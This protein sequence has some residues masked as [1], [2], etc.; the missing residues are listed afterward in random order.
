MINMVSPPKQLSRM[1]HLRFAAMVCFV[2]SI[3]AANA[4]AQVTVW[5]GPANGDF[6]SAMNWTA[7]APDAADSAIFN[8]NFSGGVTFSGSID[9]LD[10]FLRNTAGT[11]TFDVDPLNSGNLFRMS[12]FTI[13]GA[14]AGEA[15]QMVVTSG[16]L[17]TGIVLI[18]NADGANNNR[19]EVTGAGTYWKATGGTGGTAAIACRQ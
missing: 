14:A 5:N 10:L 17:E 8:N 18:G 7:G 3:I 16:D 9:T 15:N 4:M 12:R 6:L 13:V 1:P 11:I 2:A 19:V